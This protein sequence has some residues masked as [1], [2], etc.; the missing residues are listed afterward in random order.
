MA[1]L[2]YPRQFKDALRLTFSCQDS[3]FQLLSVQPIRKRVLPSDALEGYEGQTGFW[4]ELRD[5]DNRVVYRRVA[6]GPA[7]GSIEVHDPGG[8]ER[9]SIHPAEDL[10]DTF[11]IIIPNYNEAEALL[12][13]GSPQAYGLDAEAEIGSSSVEVA[14]FD[15]K[16][17]TE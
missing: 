7:N 2:M 15:L 12:F 17:I 4:Y 5:A 9:H 16:Q 13:F 1:N 8:A 6:K 14:R 3:V 10:T 11:S